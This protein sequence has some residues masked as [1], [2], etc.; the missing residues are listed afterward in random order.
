MSD[1]K[2]LRP[3]TFSARLISLA[4]LTTVSVAL[5]VGMKL[6]QSKGG[7]EYSPA[8][9]VVMT[10]IFKLGVTLLIIWRLAR[11]R[12][13]VTQ[14][15]PP[16]VISNMI[17]IFTENVTWDLIQREFLLSLAY[18]FVNVVTFP[19]FIY[20]SA[21]EFYL[22][23]AA[24]PVVTALLLRVVSHTSISRLCWLAIIMQC[25]GLVVTQVNLCNG[26]T[27]SPP[28]GYILMVANMVFSCL[29]GVYNEKI[30]KT[31]NSSLNAQNVILY[32]FGILLN[33]VLHFAVPAK[34]LGIAKKP[35]FFDGYSPSALLVVFSNGSVG[36]VISAVYKYADVVVKTF[37]VASSTSVLF[38]LESLG[39]VPRG[40]EKPSLS[41]TLCGAT[42]IFYAAYVYIAPEPNGST[43]YARLET[44]DAGDEGAAKKIPTLKGVKTN[45]EGTVEAAAPP[46]HLRRVCKNGGGH[47]FVLFLMGAVTVS[48][49]FFEYEGCA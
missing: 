18:A 11:A 20:M 22:L 40:R 34:Y 43:V 26:M 12:E 35:G 13:I 44:E 24:S 1:R 46:L 45:A 38:V 25:L 41:L 4:A 29:A 5:G 3:P 23:K 7:Y 6:S 10:E 19:I 28:L 36:L 15:P 14:S 30:I 21:S 42:V 16:S 47:A 37:G 27:T 49:I 31:Q 9:A 48:V 8:G 2:E 39:L 32:C 33:T 17:R